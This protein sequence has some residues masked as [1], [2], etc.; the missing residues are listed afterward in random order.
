[1]GVRSGSS[2]SGRCWPVVCVLVMAFFE[3]A[4]GSDYDHHS[5]TLR[6][7]AALSRLATYGDVAAGGGASAASKW[8]SAVN[9]ASCATQPRKGR[10]VNLSGQVVGI[11]FEEGNRLRLTSE[12]VTIDAGEWGV[13]LPAIAQIRTNSSTARSG[14]DFELEGSYYQLQWGKRVSETTAVGL[15]LAYTRSESR[16]K[17]GSINVTK[18]DGPGYTARLGLLHEA[19]ERVRVGLVCEYSRAPS[20]TIYYDFMRLGI[21]DIKVRDTTHQ[22]LVR[23]G[24]SFEYK[25]DSAVYLDYQFGWFSD[26]T[27]R[28]RVHRIYAGIDH[29]LLEGFYVRAGLAWDNREDTPAWTC[30][31]GI[32]PTDR[33]TLDIGYQYDMFPELGPEFGHSHT[34]VASMALAF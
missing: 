5:F 31:V 30:G 12:A 29:E 3:Q 18:A 9:P 7:P 23:P 6:L 1:M 13:F 17:L 32:Y 34:V 19:T 33:F 25:P 21:G 22:V 15:T 8:E 11:W 26:D 14:L 20:T 28:L 27:G 10:R 4:A 16:F 2:V 24:I